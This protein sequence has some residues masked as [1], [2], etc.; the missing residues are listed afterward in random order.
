MDAVNGYIEKGT[1]TCVLRVQMPLFKII[2]CN[3][4]KLRY[5]YYNFCIYVIL[6]LISIAAGAALGMFTCTWPPM[7]I[8]YKAE[9]ENNTADGSVAEEHYVSC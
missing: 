2:K 9:R 8:E 3:G 7:Y 6:W 1:C 4:M 5:L